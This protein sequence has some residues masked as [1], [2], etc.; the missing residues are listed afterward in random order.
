MFLS[1]GLDC[2]MILGAQCLWNEYREVVLHLSTANKH[3]YSPNRQE[4]SS[5][6][7][8]HIS[9]HSTPPLRSIRINKLR[10]WEELGRARATYF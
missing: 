10:R 3:P 4:P 2:N 8:Q 7:S 1:L 6:N 9:G 5:T